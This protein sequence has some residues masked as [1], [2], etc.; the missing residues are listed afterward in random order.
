MLAIQ[1]PGRTDRTT[2][3]TQEAT[4][5]V[6]MIRLT[7]R[8]IDQSKSQSRPASISLLASA[9]GLVKMTS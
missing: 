8:I 3:I 4:A 5:R 7:Q 1:R 2:P 9:V 6:G